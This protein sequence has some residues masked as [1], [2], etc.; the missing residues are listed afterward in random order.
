MREYGKNAPKM[1]EDQTQWRSQLTERAKQKFPN[2]DPDQP[3][4]YIDVDGQKYPDPK[5]DT[6]PIKFPR[7]YL[8]MLPA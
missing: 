8:I 3:H 7:L 1:R 2:P 4:P 6:T 5:D